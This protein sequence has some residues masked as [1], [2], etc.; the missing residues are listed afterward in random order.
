[1]GLELRFLARGLTN[2]PLCH[3]L[4]STSQGAKTHRQTERNEEKL[5]LEGMERKESVVR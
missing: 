4:G 1:M 3:Q 2:P 5:E